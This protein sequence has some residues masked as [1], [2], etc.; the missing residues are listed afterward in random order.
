L[1]WGL[2]LASDTSLARVV[3]TRTGI[4]GVVGR[5]RTHFSWR[6]AVD[7]VGG[8]LATL[9]KDAVIEP[10]IEA[11]RGKIEFA[12]ARPQ[13]EIGGYRAMFDLALTDDSTEPIDLRMYLRVGA[14]PMTETWMYQWIPPP[15]ATREKASR[16]PRNERS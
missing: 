6:F 1:R 8:G 12:S 10:V 11:S 5:P 16:S 14:Q 3:A 13:S 4:G 2:D 15:P 7:F 9:G